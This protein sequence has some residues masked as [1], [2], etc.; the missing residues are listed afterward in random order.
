MRTPIKLLVYQ[1]D[2]KLQPFKGLEKQI[3]PEKGW[4]NAIRTSLN[5]T[6]DQLGAKLNTSK[7]SIKQLEDREK[8]GAISIKTMN[9]VAESLEMHFVYGFVPKQ[10]SI[11]N[12]VNL[13][14]E[15]LARKIVMRTNQTMKLENQGTS[16]ANINRAIEELASELKR[17]MHKSLWD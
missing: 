16:E 14:A 9:E 6:L 4:I 1:L 17:E 13:K 8:T 15:R 3:Q 12:L 11:E 7:Q 2:K 10:G 5:M